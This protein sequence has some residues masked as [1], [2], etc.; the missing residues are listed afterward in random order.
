MLFN[1]FNKKGLII[2]FNN[3]WLNFIKSFKDR[4]IDVYEFKDLFE[5]MYLKFVMVIIV[6][7]KVFM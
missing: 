7:M 1:I 2:W 3:F 6:C 4:D 5:G